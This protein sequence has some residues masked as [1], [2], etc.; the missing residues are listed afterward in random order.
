M[1]Y[2]Y[3][4]SQLPNISSS[5]GKSALPLNTEQFRELA[6]DFDVADFFGGYDRNQD[7]HVQPDF[8]VVDSAGITP[9]D[10]AFFQPSQP[11]QRSRRHQV[12]PPGKFLVA[13]PSIV[14]QTI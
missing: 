1:A 3:L 4:V 2:Y 14:S 7:I 12:D 10:P 13:D 8:A 6:A 9:D 5:E 11:F